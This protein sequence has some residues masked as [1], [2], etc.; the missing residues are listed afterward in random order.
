MFNTNH[1]DKEHLL[2]RKIIL[3]SFMT[4][5]QRFSFLKNSFV[6]V[7]KE[8][9]KNSIDTDHPKSFSTNFITLQIQPL[10]VSY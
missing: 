4:F 7:Y 8:N 2:N 6:F 3:N 1:K 10:I 5:G 9:N